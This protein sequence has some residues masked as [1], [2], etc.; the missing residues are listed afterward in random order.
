MNRIDRL[1]AIQ[2]YLQ[3][4]RFVHAEQIAEKFKISIRTVYRDVK[5]LCESGIPVAFEPSKG[6]YISRSFFLPPISFSPEEAGALLIMEGA[7]RIF[8]DRSIQR[9]YS[10]ALTK[11]RAV[12]RESQLEGM[13]K[14]SA[15]LGMQLSPCMVA[16]YDHLASLQQAVGKRHILKIEYQDKSGTNSH[17][18]VEPIGLMFYAFSWHLMAWCHER[19]DYRDFKV[20]RI[21]N[22]QD[23][24]EHFHK[25][26]HLSLQQLCFDLPVNY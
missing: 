19:Q 13:E 1:Y 16:N 4:L 21:L 25:T 7:T 9:L 5:A 6:Y 26:D 22:I 12:M 18:S 14:L 10:E 11:I 24:L 3:S 20:S 23:T 17:R 15:G 2:V 8:A